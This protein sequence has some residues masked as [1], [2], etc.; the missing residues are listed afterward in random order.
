MVIVLGLSACSRPNPTKPSPASTPTQPNVLAAPTNRPIPTIVATGLGLAGRI[1]FISGGDIWIWEGEQARQIT[2]SGDI[3]QPALAPDGHHVA[4]IRRSQSAS[5]LMVLDLTTNETRQIT[6]YIPDLPEGSIDRVYASMWALYPAWSPDASEIAF[7]SQ[8]GPPYGSLASD[9][10]L[11]LY[12]IPPQPGADRSMRYTD[13]NG[14]VGRVTYLPNGTAILFALEPDPPGLPQIY[15]YDRT[16]GEAG[17]LPGLPEQSY[18]PAV[19][20]D[21]KRLAFAARHANGTD[22]FIMPLDG[23]TA[24]QLTT[25]GAA[26][27]PAFSPDGKHLA[28]L[29][30]ANGERGFDVWV[31]DLTSTSP[32]TPHRISFDL[33]VDANSGLSWG[34]WHGACAACCPTLSSS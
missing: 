25:S 15:R 5:D 10:R 20:P 32:R 13:E 21:G 2:H 4:Y 3:A 14:H 6:N 9:Y 16:S 18:D 8:Y 12:T 29:S 23:G 7:V 17:A 33:S 24:V 22:I 19:S 28:Y 30:T 1:V 31:I 11:G 27:A 26:R 34:T